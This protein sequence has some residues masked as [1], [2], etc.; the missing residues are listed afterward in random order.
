MRL[1]GSAPL[2]RSPAFS[3]KRVAWQESDDRLHGRR[4]HEPYARFTPRAPT[5]DDVAALVLSQRH[6]S[7]HLGAHDRFRLADGERL[8]IA[9]A[10]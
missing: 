1:P 4:P 8:V 3:D 6:A 9:L 2:D 10:T 5:C 7:D